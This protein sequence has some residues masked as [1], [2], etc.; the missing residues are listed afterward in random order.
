MKARKV[1]T[2]R[3]IHTEKHPELPYI[4]TTGSQKI[5]KLTSPD[6]TKHDWADKS[7]LMNIN[8]VFSMSQ[9]QE[10]CLIDN[11]YWW[12]S[13][14]GILNIFFD[15]AVLLTNKKNFPIQLYSKF[16]FDII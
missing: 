8:L 12:F 3:Q 16:P 5:Y 7:W 15:F 14:N 9:S 2:H 1:V 4:V 13:L 11:I 10:N 6:E